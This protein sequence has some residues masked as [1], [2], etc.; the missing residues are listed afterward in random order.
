MHIA[1][2]RIEVSIETM[3]SAMRG[4]SQEVEEELQSL[5]VGGPNKHSWDK[6]GRII[7]LESEDLEVKSS[8]CHTC[9]TKASDS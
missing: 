2:H 7:Y 6:L 9:V 8:F 1:N 5:R 4:T 3:N